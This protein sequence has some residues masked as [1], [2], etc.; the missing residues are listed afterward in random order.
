M[1]AIALVQIAPGLFFFLSFAKRRYVGI[2]SPAG[3]GMRSCQL[4]EEEV[5]QVKC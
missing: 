1:N 3:K 2:A 4:A 5:R